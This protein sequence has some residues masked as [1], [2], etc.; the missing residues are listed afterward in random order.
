MANVDTKTLLGRDRSDLILRGR[1]QHSDSTKKFSETDIINMLVLG[2]IDSI[3]VMFGGHVFQHMGTNCALLLPDL[4]LYSYRRMRQTSSSSNKVHVSLTTTISGFR[5][6]MTF[7]I[8][9]FLLLILWIYQYAWMDKFYF[10]WCSEIEG[11]DLLDV[12]RFIDHVLIVKYLCTWAS[13]EKRKEASL[14]L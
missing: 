9:S 5:I 1:K 4:F 12:D 14:I 11:L 10:C 6:S 3:F 2:L 8:I 13:Q 7:H